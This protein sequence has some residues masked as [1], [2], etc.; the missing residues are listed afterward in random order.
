MAD[1]LF[2]FQ[3]LRSIAMTNSNVKDGRGQGQSY[4]MLLILNIAS[5]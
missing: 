1:R 2:K 4:P 5:K 3:H